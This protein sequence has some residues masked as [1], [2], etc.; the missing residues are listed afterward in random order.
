M[1][2]SATIPQI[3]N[4]VSCKSIGESLLA[5]V[6]WIDETTAYCQ[7]PGQIKHTGPTGPKDCRL[8]VDG[9]PTIYCVHASC[10]DEIENANRALRAGNPSSFP[11]VLTSEEKKAVA[12]KKAKARQNQELKVRAQKSLP[13]ILKAYDWPYNRIVADS[14]N[15]L[16]EDDWEGML[17][18]FLGMFE[19]GEVIWIGDVNQ[20]GQAH[21]TSNFKTKSD[22]QAGLARVG[23]FTCPSCFVPGSCSRSK[24]NVALQRYVVVESD[25]LPK[26]EVGA[27]FRWL[28]EA[29]ELPLLAVVDTAGKSL[30]GWFQFPPP[31]VLAELQIML[32]AMGCDPKM[33]GSSQPCRL[34]GGLRDGRIQRLIYSKNGGVQ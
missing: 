3:E 13:G 7:C 23:P 1:S 25:S 8:K 6:E 9:V 20:T 17:E 19:D 18:A 16:V 26:N 29:V 12:A 10:R 33:F 4:N 34:P 14:P 24:E 11:A 2:A 21:H 5:D 22:W 31:D 27:I 28:D 30:H 32:P 15:R